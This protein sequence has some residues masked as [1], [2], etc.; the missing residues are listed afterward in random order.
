MARPKSATVATRDTEIY[1]RWNNG[2]R[3]LAALAKD[4]DISP[5]RIGQ[6]VA[7]KDREVYAAWKSGRYTFADLADLYDLS[8]E[9]VT[10]I[11]TERHPEQKDEAISRAVLRSRIE[12]LTIAIQEVIENPGFKL[13][14][15]G[16]LATDD[17]GNPVVDVTARIEAIKVQLNAY[18]NLAVL[19][20]DEKPQRSLVSHEIADRQRSEAWAAVVAQREAEL[21]EMEELRRGNRPPVVPGEVVRE[22]GPAQPE[23]S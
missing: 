5:Q 13:A 7:A 22:I 2:E 18:K 10:R 12:L 3:N 8:P 14:P 16:R 23:A 9:D 21:R 11:V 6:V 19:N 4:Y 15:N 1:A 20:G 17:D